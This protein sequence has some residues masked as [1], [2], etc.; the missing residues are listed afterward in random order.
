MNKE[1]LK[2]CIDMLLLSILDQNDSYGYELCKIVKLKSENQYLIA[3]GTLYPSLKRLEASELINA[4]WVELSNKKKRKYYSIT[5]SGKMELE[6]RQA[7]WAF[8]LL[9][10]KKIRGEQ[11]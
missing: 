1:I 7:E 8:I 10:V 9:L 3:E 6:N 11:I 4:Y 5:V 2:G